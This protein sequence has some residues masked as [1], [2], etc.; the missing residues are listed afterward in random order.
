[1]SEEKTVPQ[2]YKVRGRPNISALEDA[3]KMAS[4]MSKSPDKDVAHFGEVLARITG[5]LCELR[6]A[7]LAIQKQ[8]A[9]NRGSKKIFYTSAQ[10]SVR[11]D[12]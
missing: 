10:A 2:K 1:M 7:Q 6:K 3:G 11:E 12:D 9:V 8:R 5:K 4:G